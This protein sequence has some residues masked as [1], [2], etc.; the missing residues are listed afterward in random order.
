[1]ELS[2]AV[3]RRHMVR[4]FTDEPVEAAVVDRLLDASRRA[5]SAG[6]T[7]GLHFLVLHGAEQTA[8]YWDVTLPP[9]RRRSF[10]W[11][12]LLAAPVL[13]VPWVCPEAYVA[14]YGEPD[15]TGTGLGTGMHAWPVPYWFVDG[16]M[17]VDHLLLG[18]V[19][20]GLGACLFGQFSHEPAV[21]AAFGVPEGWRAVGTV[22][23]GHAA[24]AAPGRS[25]ARPRPPLG[26]IVHRGG[27]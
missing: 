9:A 1:M 21:R 20:T 15:K 12:G 26:D 5:P 17:A 18:A 19:D 22:A 23:L 25:A 3:R 16:G 14:R 13:V 2:D 24:P 27:W 8:R 6:N 7:S 4:A 10:R 11:P